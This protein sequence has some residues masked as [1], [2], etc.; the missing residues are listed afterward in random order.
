ME[1]NSFQILFENLPLGVVF[2]GPAGTVVAA[3]PRVL[4]IL[5]L[6]KEQILGH[7]TYNP[8]RPLVR[9]DGSNYPQEEYPSVIAYTTGKPVEG[10]IMGVLRPERAISS[11]L[12]VSAIPL[13][14]EDGQVLR[15]V[16]VTYLDITEQREAMESCEREMHSLEQ[17]S[18]PVPAGVTAASL[19]I[20]GLREASAELFAD[21]TERFADLLA[22]A[23]EMLAIKVDYNIQAKIGEISEALGSMR[24]GP[25][26]A[27]EIFL[28]ALQKNCMGVS[29]EKCR[30]YREEGRIMLI[31]LIG[32]LAVYYRNHCMGTAPQAAKPAN[33]EK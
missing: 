20:K 12:S 14:A 29:T 3:N 2:L 33:G 19:G 18:A 30:A 4:D 16:L 17:M 7:T 11:W 25:R 24:A 26:D 5:G 13:F 28:A 6:S 31:E 8:A 10:A 22:K 15:G 9:V 27:T 1:D 32:K 21:L 23:V